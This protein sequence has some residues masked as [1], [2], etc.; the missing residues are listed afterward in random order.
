[1][2]ISLNRSFT[3]EPSSIVIE[4]IVELGDF[5][6]R[7]R[8]RIVR[9]S[10]VHGR[11]GQVQEHRPTRVVLVDQSHRLLRENVRGILTVQ[12]P[13]WLHAPSHVQAPIRLHF[14]HVIVFDNKDRDL[15]N[16]L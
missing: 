12:V 15:F 9:V 14:Y 5:L 3:C 8:K 7:R 11:V 6:V 2:L 13:R 4:D 16:T 10:G 1:M